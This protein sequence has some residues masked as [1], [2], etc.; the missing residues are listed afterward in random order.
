VKPGEKWKPKEG[1][2]GGFE[3]VEVSDEAVTVEVQR[4]IRDKDKRR[5]L[6]RRRRV[7]PLS[8]FPIFSAGYERTSVR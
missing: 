7:V 8:D 6:E 5:K 4:V 2:P 3:V 1:R